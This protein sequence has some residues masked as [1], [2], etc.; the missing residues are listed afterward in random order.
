[1]KMFMKHPLVQFKIISLLK[2]SAG[3]I[4]RSYISSD[5]VIDYLNKSTK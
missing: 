4:V 3:D 2:K 5:R 1:M